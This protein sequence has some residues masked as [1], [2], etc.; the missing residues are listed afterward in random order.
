MLM[1]MYVEFLKQILYFEMLAF[2]SFKLIF[3]AWI[4]GWNL[5]K[6]DLFGIMIWVYSFVR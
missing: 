6:H 2:E 4:A 5:A 1:D 3:I